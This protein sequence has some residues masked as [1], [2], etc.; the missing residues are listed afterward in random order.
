M[1]FVMAHVETEEG[2]AIAR[3]MSWP[4]MYARLHTALSWLTDDEMQQLVEMAEAMVCERA[5]GDR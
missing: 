2:R 3:D 1:G 4:E 5:R